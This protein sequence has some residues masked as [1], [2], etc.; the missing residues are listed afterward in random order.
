MFDHVRVL[1][2]FFT[3][4]AFPSGAL[5]GRHKA[6]AQ[7]IRKVRRHARYR[8]LRV[9][10]DLDRKVRERACFE[11]ADDGLRVSCACILISLDRGHK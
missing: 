10:T 9:C 6:I 1:D 11:C 3:S 7:P 4:S 5:S 8:V 2:F